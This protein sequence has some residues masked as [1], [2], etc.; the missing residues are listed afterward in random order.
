[1]TAAKYYDT[2][3]GTWKYLLQ[4]PKGDKGDKGFN[5]SIAGSIVRKPVKRFNGTTTDY[6][7]VKRSV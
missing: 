4:G 7:A 6:V 5:V 3:T 1:M 2:T